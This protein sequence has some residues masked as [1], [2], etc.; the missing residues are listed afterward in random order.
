LFKWL[1]SI[2]LGYLCQ[3]PK[4]QKLPL[5][6][7]SALLTFPVSKSTY[8]ATFSFSKPIFKGSFRNCHHYV[9]DILIDI[10]LTYCR[11]L[12]FNNKNKTALPFY[13]AKKFFKN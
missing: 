6:S 2:V 4:A 1:P 8:S 5:F 13:P 11:F 9:N 12:T 10:T 3:P 7:S